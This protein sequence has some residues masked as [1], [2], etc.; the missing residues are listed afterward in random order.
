[1]NFAMPYV[2]SVATEILS[3]IYF[4]NAIAAQRTGGDPV[5]WIRKLT[6][7]ATSE[8]SS[9]D[10]VTVYKINTASLLLGM[11]L[12]VHGGVEESTWKA[13]FRNS[14][15]QAVDMLGDDD[16]M[17]NQFAYGTLATTLLAA[18]DRLN[19]T[20]A[21]AV[22]MKPLEA[23]SDPLL[24]GQ[25]K[26]I[27]FGLFWWCDGPCNTRVTQYKGPTYKEIHFC[28]NCLDICFCGDCFRLIK[29]DNLPFV[30]CS[31]EHKFF[32]A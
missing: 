20:A 30:K 4:C 12:R 21:L 22:T 6:T 18:G 23:S 26:E 27:N 13:C 32:Q 9:S 17:N 31:P 24:F 11:Y 29:D 1:M 8:D 3:Q 25:L 5:S 7:L 14:V 15:L 16:P 2:S 28:E 19:A 10:S